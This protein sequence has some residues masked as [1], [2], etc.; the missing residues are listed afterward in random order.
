MRQRRIDG[1]SVAASGS[2]LRMRFASA[3]STHVR[4]AGNRSI[5]ECNSQGSDPGFAPSGH[6]IPGL[7]ITF[8]LDGDGAAVLAFELVLDELVG[9]AGDLDAVGQAL[10][11]HGR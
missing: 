2:S 10:G 8:A 5:N 6:E 7:D 3:S 4:I 9:G 11:P 1:V